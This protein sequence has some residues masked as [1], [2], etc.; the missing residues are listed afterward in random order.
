[1]DILAKLRRKQDVTVVMVSHDLNLAAMY[2]D[3]VLVLEKGRARACG[4]PEDVMNAK[5]LEQVYGCRMLVER[6]GDPGLLT[7]VPLPEQYRQA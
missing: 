2:A 4:A 6:I 5:L 7:A 3:R 1:M